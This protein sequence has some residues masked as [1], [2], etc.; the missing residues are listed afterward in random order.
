MFFFVKP[1]P[2]PLM[3]LSKHNIFFLMSNVSKLYFFYLTSLETYENNKISNKT[4]AVDVVY[5]YGL[6]Y[7]EK[8]ALQNTVVDLVRKMLIEDDST[9]LYLKSV[10]IH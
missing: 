9:V 3:P 7:D 8:R 10:S 2:Y 1:L 6:E 5:L 4:V